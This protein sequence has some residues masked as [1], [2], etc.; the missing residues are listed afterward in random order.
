MTNVKN[1]FYNHDNNSL[2]NT[3]SATD[4]STTSQY[5]YSFNYPTNDSSFSTELNNKKK[6]SYLM[7]SQYTQQNR[8]TFL[9]H[10]NNSEKYYQLATP[11]TRNLSMN[12][13]LESDSKFDVN[14]NNK[15]YRNDEDHNSI[16][17]DGSSRNGATVRER[18]RMHILN[19]AFDDL[20]K[21]VPKSNLSEHQRLSKIATLRLAI[22]YIGALT[23]ILQNSGGL[24]PV[25]P[26]LLPVTPR[27]RRRKKAAIVE[28]QNAINEK[29][30]ATKRVLKATILADH[31]LKH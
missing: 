2:L 23:K 21:I 14:Q 18:N 11:I 29:T 22:H 25:D 9:N 13:E 17:S 6:N 26:S 15:K 3:N 28:A 5:S 4:L 16:E 8:E 1:M 27:R 20:R 31:S 24:K 10:N 12:P 7:D 30:M 19:D